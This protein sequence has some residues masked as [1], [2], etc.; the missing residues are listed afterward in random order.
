MTLQLREG[1]GV[2]EDVNLFVYRATDPNKLKNI[3]KSVEVS[4]RISVS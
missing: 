3:E 1:C 4:L 2:L